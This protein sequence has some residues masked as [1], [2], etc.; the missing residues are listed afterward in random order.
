MSKIVLS[1]GHVLFYFV[2]LTNMAI[3]TSPHPFCLL[4]NS[5]IAVKQAQASRVVYC[6]LIQ[7]GE[8][9]EQIYKLF[10][11]YCLDRRAEQN[12]TASSKLFYLD[13]MELER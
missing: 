4:H 10:F 2:N 12:L 11:S 6:E 5:E 3:S 1:E 7:K 8:A 9:T 13:F